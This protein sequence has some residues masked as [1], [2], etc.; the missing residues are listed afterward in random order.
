MTTDMSQTELGAR[1]AEALKALLSQVSGVRLTEVKREPLARGQAAEIVAR[2]DVFGQTHTLACEVHSD[3]EPDHVR[4]ALHGLRDSAAHLPAN[5]TPL[6]IAPY[7]S[8][9]AQAFCKENQAGFLDL[10]GNARLTVGEVFI[11]MRSLPCHAT[12]RLS[13]AYHQPPAR[14]PANEIAYDGL[15]RPS[16][17]QAASALVA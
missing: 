9:E 7:L 12:G 3:G 13:A 1:A 10:E 17:S 15:R 8:P 6:L 14:S 2:I 11:G 4:A 5:T 16:R